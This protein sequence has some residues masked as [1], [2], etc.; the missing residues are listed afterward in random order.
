VFRAVVNANKPA[1]DPSF[2]SNLFALTPIP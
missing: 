2:R 1:S